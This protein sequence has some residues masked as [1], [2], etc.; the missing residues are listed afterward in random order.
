MQRFF[1]LIAAAMA[2]AWIGMFAGV[3]ARAV[4]PPRA[5]ETTP[6]ASTDASMDASMGESL[7]GYAAADFRA[8]PPVP[9]LRFHDVRL[10]HIVSPDGSRQ[11]LLCGEFSSGRPGEPD[12]RTRFAT[13][14]TSGYEQWIGAQAS[15]LC[16]HTST[17]SGVGEDL[18]PELQ[19][20]FDAWAPNG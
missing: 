12:V 15:G 14:S 10:A 20:R 11:Y 1:S 2:V 17:D 16:E 5:A 19:Q 6:Q 13:V 9:D 18:T 7:I 8:H 3:E 4:A